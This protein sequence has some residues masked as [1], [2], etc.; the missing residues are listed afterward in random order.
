MRKQPEEQQELQELPPS[1]LEQV[2]HNLDGNYPRPLNETY[3]TAPRASFVPVDSSPLAKRTA[4]PH[5]SNSSSG[6]PHSSGHRY[7]SFPL[8]SLLPE[9]PSPEVGRGA[10][11]RISLSEGDITTGGYYDHIANYA[12]SSVY[13]NTDLERSGYPPSLSSKRKSNPFGPITPVT[14]DF[15]SEIGRKSIY[16]FADS[17]GVSSRRSSR[18]LTQELLRSPKLKENQ[19][20]DTISGFINQY[21]GREGTESP[22]ASSILE[23]PNQAQHPPL[24]FGFSQLDFGLQRGSGQVGSSSQRSSFSAVVSPIRAGH[25]RKPAITRGPGP[26]PQ[27]PPPLAPAFEYEEDSQ[28]FQRLGPSEMFSGGSSYEDT[29]Q[30]LHLSQPLAAEIVS[31]PMGANVPAILQTIPEPSSSHS[32][33]A[34]PKTLEPSSSYSQPEAPKGLEPSSSYSQPDG[35]KH[36]E[37][38]SSYSRSAGQTS[39]QTP[40]EALDQAEQIFGEA[41]TVKEKDGI[42]SMWARRHSGNFLP[43]NKRTSAVS[44]TGNDSITDIDDNDAED[45][46]GDWETIDKTSRLGRLSMEDSVANYSSTEGSRATLELVEDVSLPVLGGDYTIGPLSTVEQPVERE[47]SFYRHPSPLVQHAHPFTSS[48]PDLRTRISVRSAPEESP[49]LPYTSSPPISSTAPLLRDSSRNSYAPNPYH[50]TQWRPGFY[51]M[52]DN[53]QELLNSGPNE[54]ILY[55]ERREVSEMSQ[56]S[57]PHSDRVEPS[58]STPSVQRENTFEKLTVLGPKRNLTGTPQG[59]GM[60]EVGSSLADSSSPGALF[61][62]TPSGRQ[63]GFYASSPSRTSSVTRIRTSSLSVPSSSPHERNPSACALFS[64]A[65]SMNNQPTIS[66]PLAGTDTKPISDDRRRRHSTKSPTS[67]CKRSIGHGRAA[68]PGQ[69]KLREMI[70]APDAQTISSGHSTYFSHFIGDRPSTSHTESPLRAQQSEISFR[71]NLASEHS[72]HLLCPEV[73]LDQAF[74][75]QQLHKSWIIFGFFCVLP[76]LLILYRFGVADAIIEMWT[77]GETTKCSGKVKKVAFW[78]GIASTMTISAAITIPILVTHAA[79]AL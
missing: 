37:A 44:S 63:T 34:A 73:A 71:N 47:S 60:H 22:L 15:P 2:T 7:S 46:R 6:Y 32:Q 56:P 41:E 12:R 20:T 35:R 13:T 72:P 4:D 5:L 18:P 61:G 21:S 36:L 51:D 29:R 1:P 33:T 62:F 75:D 38:S 42:P 68:V 57:L 11:P 30:L 58:S 26:P 27:T 8:T 66:S 76:P 65:H 25:A 74:I 69:T 19:K 45:D 10:E 3:R 16:S 59:T 79:G 48:P 9:G 67:P 14:E 28:T 78:T 53:E 70:L 43:R 50:Y 24:A 23:G 54:E 39:P 64:A 55:E 77:K 17:S 40:Q 52:S 49:V 31:Q